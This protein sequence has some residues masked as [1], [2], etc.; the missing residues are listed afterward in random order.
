MF[1]KVTLYFE[2]KRGIDKLIN[3]DRLSSGERN[4]STGLRTILFC[5][6]VKHGD[7]IKLSMITSSE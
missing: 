1:T 6:S 4:I 2:E 5:F 3:K 7:L